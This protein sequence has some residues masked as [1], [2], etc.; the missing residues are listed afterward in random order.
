MGGHSHWA[1]TKRHKG[2]V[3]VKRGK[4]FTKVVASATA[5]SATTRVTDTA[6]GCATTPGSTTE[7]CPAGTMVH[8]DLAA[9]GSHAVEVAVAGRLQL[10]QQLEQPAVR[11]RLTPGERDVVELDAIEQAREPY[12]HI[13]PGLPGMF[14]YMIWSTEGFPRIVNGYSDDRC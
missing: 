11:E 12:V 5:K 4:T 2:V 9:F 14:S 8:E 10:R 1:T 3:D 6:T 7:T 13:P